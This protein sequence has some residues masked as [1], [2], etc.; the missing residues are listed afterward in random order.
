MSNDK[1]NVYIASLNASIDKRRDNEAKNVNK[2]ATFFDKLEK[3]RSEVTHASVANVMLA[4]NVDADY[5]NSKN[6]SNIY[7]AQKVAKIARFLAASD[8]FDVHTLNVFLTC[9]KLTKAEKSMTHSDAKA[10]ICSNIKSTV[11]KQAFI[12][13]S[14][15]FYDTSTAN[16]Q[17]SSSISA[18]QIF[19]MLR[20]TRDER[21]DEA[22]T[23]DFDNKSVKKA[24]KLLKLEA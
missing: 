7:T 13:V 5:I 4:S 14:A 12:N 2:A 10:A 6:V 8:S 16:A 21:N 19:N 18:L 24:L 20:K 22:Y 1:L 3:H 15:K 23:L 11:E 17:S 9:F